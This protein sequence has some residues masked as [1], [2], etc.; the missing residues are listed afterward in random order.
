MARGYAGAFGGKKINTSPVW[1]AL[2]RRSSCS[3]SPTG[4]GRSRCGTSTCSRCSRS[5]SRSGTS[6]SGDVFTSVPL[7]YPPLV[8]LLA[9]RASGSAGAGARRA[10]RAAVWPVWV[11]AAATVFLTGFRIGLN[12]RDSN[13]IDVGYSGV[14][15]AQRIA[16]GEIAVRPLP[17]RGRPEGV[18]A[19]GRA[20]ARSASGSRR[21]AAAS[22]ANAARRHL[23]PRR[24]RGVPARLPG[25]RLDGKWDDL[26]AAH[27]T[28][29]AFD[30]ALRCSGSRSLGRRFGGRAA[31]RRRS[32]SRGRRT[33][34]RSTC[35]ARTRTTR[36]RR[37]S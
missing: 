30:L 24:L 4:A 3:G 21:T 29:I 28:S 36:S 22:R 32:R 5:R 13:V 14:I 8:Y 7:V 9:P 6:T 19:G 26:P 23:R 11:L 37:R 18:R 20:T 12:V 2:L 17:G 16:H 34:S 1:L 33:R 25:A 35:R 27:F 15:G 31:R 10:R